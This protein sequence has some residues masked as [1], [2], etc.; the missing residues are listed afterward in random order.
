MRRDQ[1]RCSR[2]IWDEWALEVPAE[3]KTTMQGFASAMEVSQE[4]PAAIHMIGIKKHGT[5]TVS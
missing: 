3:A 1:G 5:E 4:E 2:A